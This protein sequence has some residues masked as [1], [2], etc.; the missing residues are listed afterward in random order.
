MRDRLDLSQA[1][2]SHL[3]KAAKACVVNCTK[4]YDKEKLML[5]VHMLLTHNKNALM[6]AQSNNA[7]GDSPVILKRPVTSRSV[8]WNCMKVMDVNNLRTMKHTPNHTL[9]CALYSMTL[10]LS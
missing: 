1:V 6:D 2:E 9:Q 4:K 8:C 3:N 5:A 7:Q 10:P